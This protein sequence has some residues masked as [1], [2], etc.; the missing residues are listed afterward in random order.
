MLN[1]LI[2]GR[3]DSD[4][5][6]GALSGKLVRFNADPDRIEVLRVPGEGELRT[7]LDSYTQQ[8]LNDVWKNYSR[9][10]DGDADGKKALAAF[11]TAPGNRMF[12]IRPKYL[13]EKLPN[14]Y[15]KKGKGKPY[16]GI[17]RHISE[18]SLE[19]QHEIMRKVKPSV[20]ELPEALIETARVQAM[21]YHPLSLLDET[22]D[23]LALVGRLAQ[24]ISG[25]KT[26]DGFKLTV[27]TT[28]R[29]QDILF[30]MA[31]NEWILLPVRYG[32]FKGAMAGVVGQFDRFFLSGCYLPR[33]STELIESAYKLLS[34]RESDGGL[35]T[36]RTF[37]LS[38]TVRQVEDLS[39]EI[40]RR[41][42]DVSK[43]IPGE[44]GAKTGSRVVGQALRT[45]FESKY[46]A[47]PFGD[48]RTPPRG[49][50]DLNKK[51]PTFKRVEVEYPN[52]PEMLAWGELFAKFVATRETRTTQH[53]IYNLWNWLYYIA[54]LPLPLASPADVVRTVHI[55]DKSRTRKGTFYDFLS[56]NHN[57]SKIR[58]NALHEMRRFFDWY[59]D[60]E[61]ATLQ[62]YKLERN[63][64]ELDDAFA[65]NAPGLGMTGRLAL[66]DFIL[67]AIKETIIADDFAWSKSREAE[68][69]EAFNESGNPVRIWYPGAAILLY[70][71]LDV[72]IRL[73]QG[74][75]LDDGLL[76]E[77]LLML[78][79]T[80]ADGKVIHQ[81]RWVTNN[82]P[83]RIKGRREGV[84]RT[85]QDFGSLQAFT[86]LFV[87][88]NKTDIYD[89][90]SP[91]GYEMPYVTPELLDLLTYMR[92][93]NQKWLPP[94]KAPL[95]Y[96]D[97]E[98]LHENMRDKVPTVSPL[99]RDPLGT[100]RTRPISDH[101]LRRFYVDVMRET[102][103]RLRE[104][105]YTLENGWNIELTKETEHSSGKIYISSVHDVHTLRVSGITSL[106]NK[107]VSPEVVRVA[108]S[109]HRSMAM[110]M[111]YFNP[112]SGQARNVLI[113]AYAKR[114]EEFAAINGDFASSPELHSNWEA[115]EKHFLSNVRVD[116]KSDAV[117][118]LKEGKGVWTIQADGICPGTDCAQGFLYQTEQGKQYYGAVPGGKTCSLC[119]FWIT[120]P[121]FLLGQVIRIN[122]VML[123][124]EKKTRELRT[125]KGKVRALETTKE[126]G[127]LHA[128]RARL[129]ELE[130][131]LEVHVNDW[132]SRLRFVTTSVGQLEDYKQ[133]KAAV[134]D[135]DPS[136]PVPWVTGNTV[137][138]LN[139]TLE[140]ADSFV[141][142]DSVV[143]GLQFVPGMANPEAKMDHQKLINGILRKG[144]AKH[145]LLDL[146]DDLAEEAAA[147]MSSHL[148]QAANTCGVDIRKLINGDVKLQDVLISRHGQEV[149]LLDDLNSIM[150]A[151]TDMLTCAPMRAVH[152]LEAQK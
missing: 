55:R 59:L 48:Y 7:L 115:Y 62:P 63:P 42:E 68:W 49:D 94:L 8:R 134:E 80:E 71:L 28:A 108:V 106:L 52:R 46:P 95:R 78:D 93:W 31:L 75:W 57:K 117:Y 133:T 2:M 73:K 91:N 83:Y 136:L 130:R 111:W 114:R 37:F 74:R 137:D 19:T 18:L 60:Y 132:Y 53:I 16:E 70:V 56:K 33:E 110:L 3:K 148:I 30:L 142:L 150:E 140:D 50:L 98:D 90:A 51:S 113:D 79:R 122:S 66:P 58:N 61:Q 135:G 131:D 43:A 151:A 76:D 14:F 32:A 84:L 141:V 11:K 67:E 97:G 89:G 152:A 24:E 65:A 96:L 146:P 112:Q 87:N 101:R 72:P 103:R 41:F 138:G 39:T 69:F 10:I 116:G 38:S 145:L 27:E 128:T 1:N 12:F 26:A 6:T 118:A 144:G 126:W 139:V 121:M 17:H 35:R 40:L 29:H 77:Q 23:F 88:T 120:G 54:Q 21:A 64:I 107:G 92:E 102:E 34:V 143:Q 104:R 105:G 45:V 109:A 149:P 123:T 147:L 129:L 47:E 125:L 86:A 82:H 20:E 124:V 36:L 13:F 99:F 85:I 44:T 9:E 15:R 100:T 25:R 127:A 4:A 22:P 5:L 119:R 81:T